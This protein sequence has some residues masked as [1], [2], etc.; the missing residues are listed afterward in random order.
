M[1]LDDVEPS[2]E[3][4]EDRTAATKREPR[5]WLTIAVRSWPDRPTI[6]ANSPLNQARF[7]AG[8]KPRCRP[9]ESLP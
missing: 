7:V 3:I 1:L 9:R 4:E 8:L 5:S 2:S 6:R